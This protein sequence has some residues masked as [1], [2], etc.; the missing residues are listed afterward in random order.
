MNLRQ[1]SQ[2]IKLHC[3]EDVQHEIIIWNI[4]RGTLQEPILIYTM[5]KC[6]TCNIKRRW[7]HPTQSCRGIQLCCRENKEVPYIDYIYRQ[8]Y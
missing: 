1:K 6:K 7:I 5:I 8:G 4:F 3:Y 2:S